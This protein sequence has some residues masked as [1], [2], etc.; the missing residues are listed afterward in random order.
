MS[1]REVFWQSEVNDLPIEW[2]LV[3]TWLAQPFG[4]VPRFLLPALV[5]AVEVDLCE[6][7]V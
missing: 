5:I 4:D 7:L 1:C 2:L 3:R 6:P